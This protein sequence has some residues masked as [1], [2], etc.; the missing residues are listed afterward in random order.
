[1]AGKEEFEYFGKRCTREMSDMEIH[2]LTRN[3]SLAQEERLLKIIREAE[4]KG[5]LQ[6]VLFALCRERNIYPEAVIRLMMYSGWSGA[7]GEK[8]RSAKA[9][10]DM[11]HADDRA[12]KKKVYE[13]LNAHPPKPR[14]KNAAARAIHREDFALVTLGTIRRWI[15]DWEK[16]VPI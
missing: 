1:M 3:D 2:L 13:W 8:R 12:M 7:A 11:R 4:K 6:L 10:A 15:D 16:H 9:S 14:G 5:D